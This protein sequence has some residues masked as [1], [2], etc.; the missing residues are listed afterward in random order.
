VQVSDART[1]RAGRRYDIAFNVGV[2]GPSVGLS[3]GQFPAV[4]TGGGFLSLCIP[5]FTDGAGN[6]GESTGFNASTVITVDG[7]PLEFPRPLQVPCKAIQDLP[8]RSAAYRISSVIARD[9]VVATVSTR[10]EATWTF[11]SQ[12]PAEGVTV[13]LP[14]SSVRFTPPLAPDSTASA[15][16]SLIVPLVIDGA[17]AGNRLRALS[18]EVSYDGGASWVR[19]PVQDRHGKKSVRLRHPRTA[20]SVSLRTRLTDRQGGTFAVT[21]IDAYRLKKAR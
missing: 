1:F 19:T 21:I 7:T 5:L 13:D 9:A 4:R 2:F 15:G 11:R 8:A 16:A 12:E 3:R 20:K 6:R 14:I 17:A 18:V 10:I